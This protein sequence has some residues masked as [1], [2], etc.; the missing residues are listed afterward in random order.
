[1]SNDLVFFPYQHVQRQYLTPFAKAD[2]V[3]DDCLTREL[4]K[5][6]SK[7]F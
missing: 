2:H 6:K 1:L 7:L 3:F 5:E 4:S